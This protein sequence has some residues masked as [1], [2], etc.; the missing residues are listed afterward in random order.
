M[1]YRLKLHESNVAPYLFDLELS[2]EGRI[3]LTAFLHSTLCEEGDLF[4]NN[5]E[6]RLAPGSHYFSVDL[7]FKDKKRRML[8]DLRLI[9]SDLD[10]KYGILCIDYAEDESTPTL[11]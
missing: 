5:P 11:D 1:A 7:V 3:T 2:R 4:I 8:H 10:A 9:I 6:Y